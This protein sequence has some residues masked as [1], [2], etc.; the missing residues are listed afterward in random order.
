MTNLPK[1]MARIDQSCSTVQCWL[2]AFGLDWQLP[3]RI[4]SQAGTKSVSFFIALREFI[5]QRPEYDGGHVI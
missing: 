3:K 1:T 4:L 2:Y 5:R